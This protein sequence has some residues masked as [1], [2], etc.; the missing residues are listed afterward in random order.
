MEGVG[1]P[2]VTPVPR[3]AGVGGVPAAEMQHIC[4]VPLL[5]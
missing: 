4:G 1:S 2:L 5:P 3:G